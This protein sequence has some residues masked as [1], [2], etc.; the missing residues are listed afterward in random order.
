[1]QAMVTLVVRIQAPGFQAN[2]SILNKYSQ[3]KHT[4]LSVPKSMEASLL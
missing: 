3:I 2:V 1:M 4:S